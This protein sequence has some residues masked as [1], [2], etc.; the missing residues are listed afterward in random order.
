MTTDELM[1]AL[2]EKFAAPEYVLLPQVRNCTGLSKQIRTADAIAMSLWPSRGLHLHGFEMK[3]DRRDWL[4]EKKDPA[5]A[6][7]IAR[8]CDYWWLVAGEKDVV[9]DDELPPTWGLLVPRGQALVIKSPA[10]LLT[11]QPC[12]RA[13]LAALLRKAQEY[14][15]PQA[16]IDE[17]VRRAVEQEQADW[18]KYADAELR[19][20]KR[21][22]TNLLTTVRDFEQ[23]SGVLIEHAWNVGKI[24]H[25]VR[26]VLDGGIEQAK[27]DL[28]NLHGQAEAITQQIAS[29][30]N[31]PATAPR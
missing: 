23:A 21:D 15:V 8:F 11:A 9:R 7:E 20:V 29:I 3:A 22:L 1:V 4:R 5:K 25:V 2:A 30:M 14:V 27:R 13:F 16:Q 6:D 18:K 31:Q 19:G 10:P 26:F 17:A 28:A 24:G 12:D